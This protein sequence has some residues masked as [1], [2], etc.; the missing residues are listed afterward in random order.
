MQKTFTKTLL[1]SSLSGIMCLSGGL[2]MAEQVVT[3]APK[4]VTVNGDTIDAGIINA[5][6]RRQFGEEVN[7]PPGSMPYNQVVD[8]LIGRQILFQEAIK[9]K[10]EENSDVKLELA[11]S[12]QEALVAAFMRHWF[13]TN[14]PS[15]EVLQEAYKKMPIPKE[16]KSSH[17][18]VA[19]E[20]EAKDVLAQLKG[21]TD[22]AEVAK[23]K[24]IDPITK[25]K[26]GELGWLLPM[27]MF[28][29]YFQAISTME[30]GKISEPI[31]TPV[32]WHIAKLEEVR[33]AER[34]PFDAAKMEL[35]RQLQAMQWQQFVMDLRAKAKVEAK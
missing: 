18:L 34:P 19:T 4:T 33:D 22:F 30:K 20:Q 27:Q 16:Y 21:G 3:A 13:K 29:P 8:T 5:Y 1:I 12:Q 23:T 31:N 17:I 6:I 9:A 11:D 32:G 2:A 25:E 35:S 15:D 10:I 14:P 26:G 7:F 28:P 24:S